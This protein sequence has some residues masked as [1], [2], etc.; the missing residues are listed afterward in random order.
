M[1]EAKRVIP[2]NIVV[3]GETLVDH[4]GMSNDAI[5]AAFLTN[6]NIDREDFYIEA[7]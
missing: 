3:T 2:V 6:Y 4:K 1:N 7:K 5:I